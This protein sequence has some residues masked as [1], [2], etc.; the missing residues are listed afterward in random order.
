MGNVPYSLWHLNT[1]SPIGSAVWGSLGG[2]ASLEKVNPHI[3]LMSLREDFATEF[4]SPN[5]WVL[6]II[7]IHTETMSRHPTKAYFIHNG[8]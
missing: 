4:S 1:E 2:K 8:A 3:I 5:D 6:L 7:H